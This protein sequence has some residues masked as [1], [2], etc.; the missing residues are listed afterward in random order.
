MTGRIKN[1]DERR[2]NREDYE[3]EQTMEG[4]TKRK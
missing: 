3:E 4:V 1:E 2:E